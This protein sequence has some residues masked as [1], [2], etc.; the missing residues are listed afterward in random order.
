MKK[1]VLSALC[2][3]MFFSGIYAMDVVVSDEPEDAEVHFPPFIPEREKNKKQIRRINK[4]RAALSGIV[5]L[6]C[7]GGVISSPR[8][9]ITTSTALNSTPFLNNTL[10]P[11]CGECAYSYGRPC[12][13]GKPNEPPLNADHC[14]FYA[15]NEKE[16]EEY[17][18]QQLESDRCFVLKRCTKPAKTDRSIYWSSIA[19]TLWGTYEGLRNFV[20]RK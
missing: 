18:A 11:N 1:I 5:M 16:C 14:C 10:P 19:L 15:V 8:P 12:N 9:A 2:I 7:F 3:A 13:Y 4:A 20:H 6:L 17:C